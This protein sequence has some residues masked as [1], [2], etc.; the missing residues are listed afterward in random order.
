MATDT[1][2][3]DEL[4]DKL[5]KVNQDISGT[6]E[7]LDDLKTERSELEKQL[8]QVTSGRKPRDKK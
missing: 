3:V 6:Q 2:K 4:S 7:I 1:S 8:R 5:K